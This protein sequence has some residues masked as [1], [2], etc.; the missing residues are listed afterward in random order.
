VVSRTSCAQPPATMLL[1]LRDSSKRLNPNRKGSRTSLSARAADVWSM[2][3]ALVEA[4][5]WLLAMSLVFAPWA[6]GSTRPWAVAA[7]SGSMGGV[8]LLWISE[9]VIRRRWPRVPVLAGTAVAGVLAQ[10]WWMALNAHSRFDA[11]LGAL[12]PRTSLVPTAPGSVDGGASANAMIFFTGLLGVFL[13]CCDLS[14]HPVWPRRLWVTMALT[15]V[16]IAVLGILQKIGGDAVLSLAWEAAKRDPANN[17]AMFRY[18]GNAG[19]YLNVILPLTAGLAFLAFQRREQHG[20]K[21]LWSSGLFLLVVGIQL[22]PSRASW[23]I[24]VVLGLI[25]AAKIFLFYGRRRA[26]TS[27]VLIAVAGLAV[28]LICFWG[29]WESSWGRFSELGF[30]LR[31][32][33]PVEIYL[34]MV[35]DAGVM[36]FGPGTFREIF[37]PYQATYDFGN[38]AVP[39]FWKEDYFIHAHDDYLEDLIEWGYLGT[40]FWSVLVFGGIARGMER[41]VQERGETTLRWLLFCSLLA[42]SGTLA[43][44]LIDFPLQV[45]SIQLYVFTLLGMC[46]GV[47]FF[48]SNTQPLAACR[49]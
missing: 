33:S 48:G 16:S 9:C 29:N 5:R 11:G 7:L 2:V 21:A 15:G 20:R 46:W 44:A 49:W 18:R 47:K 27:C 24:A 13:F 36:G 23:L 6:Y 28:G 26:P 12:L 42:L 17:F 43:Q 10:G 3:R 14:R 41:Y 37:E 31:D 35:P 22:N 30:G 34:R 4:P 39:V 38:R 32:R 25:V 40:L 8:V 1:S 45:A 19:A